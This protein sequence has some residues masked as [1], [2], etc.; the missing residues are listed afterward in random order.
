MA[1]LLTVQVRNQVQEVVRQFQEP[2]D[3]PFIK[4]CRIA[5]SLGV[6]Y[7]D[8]IGPYMDSMLNYFQISAWLED[9]PRALESGLLEERQRE[10]VERVLEAAREAE[11]LGGYLY[12][13]G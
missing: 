5:P 10:S 11:D 12:F 6:R 1:I 13:E 4:F 8:F 3:E 9:L 2:D 7:V